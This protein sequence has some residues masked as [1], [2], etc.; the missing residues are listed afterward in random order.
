VNSHVGPGVAF[1][2]RLLALSEATPDRTRPASLA[3]DYDQLRTAEAVSRFEAKI[4]TA[5]RSGAVSIRN[6]K[7]ERR[8]LIERVTVRD[9][10][11]L[12][13][14]LGRKPA[15]VIAHEARL[16]LEP[17]IRHGEPWLVRILD[18]IENRWTR[19]EAAFRLP[20]GE[21][22]AA[23]EFLT[24]LAAISKDQARGLD[25]RTFS[26][27]VTGDT[28][29]FDRHSTR[30]ASVMAAQLSEPAL[31]SDLTWSRIGLERFGHP[32]HL[33]GAL[34]AVD[35]RGVLVDGRIKPFASIHPE[36]LPLL[37]LSGKPSLI[38]TIENYASF[39][40]YVREINDS[41]LV[42]YTG[43]FAS[44]GVIEILRW[45][46][47]NLEPS[48]PFFHWSDI[49][50]GGLRIFRY[51]EETLPRAPRPHLMD[52]SLAAAH[53]KPAS[54]DPTLMQ[55]SKSNSAIAGIAGWL[56]SGD[57]IKHLEQEAI[58]PSSPPIGVVSETAA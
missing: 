45:L 35:D 50:P 52:K 41:G 38:L 51:L 27:R 46:L 28:K 20:S 26:L 53:G 24:L 47:N 10:S 43:G 3:P 31:T 12:A 2:T 7:R 15:M 44:A 37:R 32:V 22:E 4:L 8:H 40:R 5:Q 34:I 36:L 58:D 19:G 25:A 13:G 11:A 56:A 30:I 29:S 55:I 49:D 21:I 6:G 54:R 1:L 17:A 48:V 16:N 42:L 9:S 33:H 57:D 23:R 39:N 14:H 18:E